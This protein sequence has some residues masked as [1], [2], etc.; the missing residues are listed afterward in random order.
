MKLIQRIKFKIQGVECAKESCISRLH[1][2]YIMVKIWNGYES[3]T[4]RP[5]TKIRVHFNIYFNTQATR[6]PSAL[7]RSVFDRQCEPHLA[8][9]V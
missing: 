7:I 5:L 8:L 4:K 2:T 6:K 9:R 1:N 3:V